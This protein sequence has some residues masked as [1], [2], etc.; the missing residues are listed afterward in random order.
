MY[1]IHVR[2]ISPIHPPSYLSGHLTFLP[3]IRELEIQYR[4]EEQ[5]L[6]CIYSSI[7][8]WDH[9]RVLISI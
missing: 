5:S 8:S 4:I 6:V 7:P 9:H 3:F 1:R 2:K